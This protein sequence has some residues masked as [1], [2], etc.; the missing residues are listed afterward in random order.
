[1]VSLRRR[2]V[3]IA[4]LG[5]VVAPAAISATASAVPDKPEKLVLSGRI[6]GPGGKPLAGAAVAAGAASALTDADGRF[7]VVTTTPRY[8]VTCDGRSAEGFVSNQRRDAEGTWRST[9][10]LTLA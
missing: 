6:L 10:G 4:G 8:R 5:T 2:Q 3:I 1:M 7:M 9:F